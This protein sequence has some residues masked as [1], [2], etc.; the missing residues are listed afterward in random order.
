[1]AN[2]ESTPGRREKRP[3]PEF[4]PLE[5]GTLIV[6]LSATL[7]NVNTL[8]S[9][10]HATEL[11]ADGGVVRGYPN[12]Q[13]GQRMEVTASSQDGRTVCRASGWIC[14]FSIQRTKQS[15]LRIHG[16]KRR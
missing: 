3:G 14:N 10:P 4:F 5:P 1:M 15:F 16:V 6:G 13:V 2:N 9:S 8:L 11:I 12:R 7:G